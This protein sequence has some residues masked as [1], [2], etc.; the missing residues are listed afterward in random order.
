[1]A[2]QE[3]KQVRTIKSRE[4]LIE[5]IINA[6]KSQNNCVPVNA[7]LTKEEAIEKA[8]VLIEQHMYEYTEVVLM[9]ES[10]ININEVVWTSK[11]D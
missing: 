1:M 9:P 7:A 2:K 4:E 11:G 6:G 5:D 10:N 3:V 8:K